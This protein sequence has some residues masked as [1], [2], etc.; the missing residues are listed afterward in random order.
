MA[1]NLNTEANAVDK[2]I[3]AYL[4]RIWLSDSDFDTNFTI[5]WKDRPDVA[6][7]NKESKYCIIFENKK[8][9]KDLHWAKGQGLGYLH[10][11]QEESLLT[12]K[13]L[14]IR[15]NMVTFHAD[16]YGVQ[17]WDIIWIR[18]ITN[19]DILEDLTLDMIRSYISPVKQ[20]E[21]KL[22]STDKQELKKAFDVINNFL[23]DK[24]LG[25]DQRLHIT[26]AIL[27]LKLIK[28]NT[29]LLESISQSSE[30][31]NL[32]DELQNI[33][34]NISETNIVHVFDAINKVYNKEFRF[35]L[36]Q[37]K[38]RG[39]LLELFD[40]VDRIHLSNYDL[41]IKWEA[42]EYFINYGN[43]SSD[44]GEYF[45]PRHIVRFMVKLLDQTFDY[46]RE[47]LSDKTYFDPTCGTWWF[48]I[49]IFKQVREE[50][51]SSKNLNID[52]EEKLKTATVFWNELNLRSSEIAKMNM[53]LTWDGHSN[54][55]QGDFLILKEE[56]KNRYDVTIGNPPFWGNKEW[57][58]VDGFLK[59]VNVGWYSIFLV[60]EW[61]LFKS[62]KKKHY[63][64]NENFSKLFLCLRV[65]FFPMHE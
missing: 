38:E 14:L 8:D 24:G 25:I 51:R 31:K 6:I 35:D 13:I 17:N 60:P 30:K 29:D 28:E 9:F 61:V 58:F 49:E 22:L 21:T 55:D 50:L 62:D 41:D 33:K 46:N 37:Y 27:F 11:L 54:I 43:T 23:R 7:K 4:T 56:R 10:Q 45:T 52:T 59:D 36:E 53:I 32:L 12:E 40:I 18:D 5:K 34:I 15:T 57:T 1:I 19:I 20:E 44:M 39:V 26:M 3:I 16:E 42:F 2:K 48:L 47:K 65:Y 64:L 63:L